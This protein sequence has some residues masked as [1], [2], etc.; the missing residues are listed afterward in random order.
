MSSAVG[1]Y[2]V[3]WAIRNG[4]GMFVS[5]AGTLRIIPPQVMESSMSLLSVQPNV[6]QHV[7]VHFKTGAY[8]VLL[9]HLILFRFS[10]KV[11]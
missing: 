9:V 5:N 8:Q 11:R 1:E 3:C 6:S 2:T 10:D 4:P 7:I